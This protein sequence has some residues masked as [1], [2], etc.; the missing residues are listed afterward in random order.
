MQ[1]ETTRRDGSLPGT[2][3]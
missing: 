2:S 3:C 1:Q